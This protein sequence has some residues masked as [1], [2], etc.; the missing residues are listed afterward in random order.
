MQV[1]FVTFSLINLEILI[2]LWEILFS[3]S[4]RIDLGSSLPDGV[5]LMRVQ[6]H[7]QCIHIYITYLVL[8]AD[9]AVMH[10]LPEWNMTI[11]LFFYW[12]WKLRFAVL[13]Q[14][15]VMAAILSKKQEHCH[16]HNFYGI[17]LKLDIYKLWLKTR[18]KFEFQ[19]SSLK[20]TIQ[21]GRL[22]FAFFIQNGRQ[23]RKLLKGK[24]NV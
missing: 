23:I 2:D 22:K 3:L 19:H 18:F 15:V 21:N 14:D 5:I 11:N 8:S 6:L 4:I 16:D 17:F 9:W 13:L 7:I 20:T 1:R 24:Q 10:Y 12:F